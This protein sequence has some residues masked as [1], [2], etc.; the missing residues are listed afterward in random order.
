MEVDCG[1]RCR[2]GARFH[3]YSGRWRRGW[4]HLQC[5]GWRHLRLWGWRRHAAGL[6][7]RRSAKTGQSGGP[8]GICMAASTPV[9]GLIAVGACIAIPV[10]IQLPA[11]LNVTS[12]AHLLSIVRFNPHALS[13]FQDFFPI[14]QHL[15]RQHAQ[16]CPCPRRHGHGPLRQVCRCRCC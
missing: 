7:R 3:S 11:T 9:S 5:S 12:H 1:C 6:S 2:G 10:A 16:L 14:F 13:L 4:L 15:P 8:A